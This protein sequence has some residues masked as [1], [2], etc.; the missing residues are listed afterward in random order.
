M[1]RQDHIRSQHNRRKDRWNRARIKQLCQILEITEAELV[2]YIDWE[3]IYFDRAMAKNRFPGPV[4]IVLEL[5][6]QYAFKLHLG[7]EKELNL[8]FPK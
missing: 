4:C 1:I 5:Y 3:K 7:E 6:E 8:P 2:A